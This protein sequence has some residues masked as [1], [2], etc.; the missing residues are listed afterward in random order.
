MKDEYK[1]ISD[2]MD[3]IINT[4]GH[5]YMTIRPG[6]A[7]PAVLDKVLVSYYG[8]MTPINQMAAINISDARTLYI[9]PFDPSM[10]KEIEKAIFA[11]DIGINPVN[12]GQGLR[13]NFPSPTEERRKELVKQ[14]SKYAEEAKISVRNVRRDAIE[15][16]KALQ[17][18]SEITED[19]LKTSEKDIQNLTDKY[20][21]EIEDLAKSKEAEIMEI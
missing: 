14:V 7:D 9:K 6:R 3:K 1:Q 20:C 17:K 2:K 4:L 13:L 8:T 21:K 16:F 11:S 10:T 15:E 18:K 19:D 12:D 5:E